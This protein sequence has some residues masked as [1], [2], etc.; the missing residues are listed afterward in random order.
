MS[1]PLKKRFPTRMRPVDWRNHSWPLSHTKTI[2][3]CGVSEG[4]SVLA[5]AAG[6][7][8]LCFVPIFRHQ[9]TGIV[10]ASG[11]SVRESVNSADSA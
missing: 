5:A 6:S 7:D 2:R 10:S 11:V 4:K 1:V 9:A 8:K 3:A